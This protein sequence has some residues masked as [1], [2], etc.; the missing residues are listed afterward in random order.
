MF[1]A[2]ATGKNKNYGNKGEKIRFA[3]RYYWY[4]VK[5]DIARNIKKDSSDKLVIRDSITNEVVYP[6]RRK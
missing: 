3:D 5:N 2:I 4:V 6:T 1:K